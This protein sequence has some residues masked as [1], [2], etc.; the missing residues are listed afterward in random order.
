[1]LLKFIIENYKSFKE[2]ANLNVLAASMTD[3]EST[4]VISIAKLRVLKTLAIY[5]ANAS[6]KSNL[7]SGIE[8]MK[9]LVINSSKNMQQGEGLNVFPFVL[10]TSTENAPCKFEIEF[11]YEN[12]R[13]RYGFTADENRIHAEWFLESPKRKEYPL[14]LRKGDDIKVFDRFKEA[15]GLESKTRNNALF[16]SVCGQF[17]V[18]KAV[19]LIDWFN[20]L[21]VIHGLRDTLYAA[22]TLEFLS[23]EENLALVSHIIGQADLG[24][25]GILIEENEPTNGKYYPA[26]PPARG[27]NYSFLQDVSRVLREGET[28]KMIKTRHKTFDEHNQFQGHVDLSLEISGSEGT[29]KF[30]NLLG[31]F[32]TAILQGKTIIVDELDARMHPLLTKGI[33]DLFNSTKNPSGQMIFTT[34]DTNLLDQKMIRRDQVYFLEK[35]EFGGSQLFSLAEFKPRKETPFDKNYLKGRYGGIP[36][37]EDLTQAMP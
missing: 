18:E 36:F 19:S 23:N 10:N 28:P 34:H 4:N 37:I 32:L 29:K 30:F 11:F 7:I 20:Q 14:F 16:S 21:E 1:M 27:R 24:I 33:I 31:V 6:G 12:I 2:A 15:R 35:D 9:W 5:G 17:N 8:T 26:R 3:F 25:E 13:F 22:E